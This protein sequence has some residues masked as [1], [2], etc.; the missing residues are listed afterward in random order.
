MSSKKTKKN[1][2]PAGFQIDRCVAG[3][4]ATYARPFFH[5]YRIEPKRLVFLGR[6]SSHAAAVMAAKEAA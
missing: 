2:T 1:L 6:F 5:L 3:Y 4:G